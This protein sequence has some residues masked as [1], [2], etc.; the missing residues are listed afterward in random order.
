MNTALLLLACLAPPLQAGDLESVQAG[1]REVISRKGACDEYGLLNLEPGLS[2]L[3]APE[4]LRLA[5]ELAAR[6]P[7]CAALQVAYAKALC[8]GGLKPRAVRVLEAARLP[9]ADARLQQSLAGSWA[10]CG[11]PERAAEALAGSIA[12]AAGPHEAVLALRAL[13]QFAERGAG[14]G[15]L[16][17]LEERWRREVEAG[18]RE[19]KTYRLLAESLAAGPDPEDGLRP[20]CERALEFFPEEPAFVDLLAG[21]LLELGDWRGAEALR[22][23]RVREAAGLRSRD[24]LDLADAVAL[25]GRLSA[26]LEELAAGEADPRLIPDDREVLRDR[27]AVLRLMLRGRAEQAPA[28]DCRF[29]QD[30]GSVRVDCGGRRLEYSLAAGG[31]TGRPA[32]ERAAALACRLM[33]EVEAARFRGAAAQEALRVPAEARELLKAAGYLDR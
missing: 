9:P 33:E 13:R 16:A 20:L 11:E 14:R 28:E 17:A 32:P 21:R 30:G 26:A 29:A 22:R 2:R 1:Y 7:R 6:K 10:A 5:A 27:G 25:S 4:R 15:R 12:A 18:S 24:Y 23:R 19:L 8:A 31:F 3:P